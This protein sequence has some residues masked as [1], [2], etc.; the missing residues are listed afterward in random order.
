MDMLRSVVRSIS[1]PAQEL[2]SN[3]KEAS[4]KDWVIINNRKLIIEI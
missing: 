4:D 2:G 3:A 1:V